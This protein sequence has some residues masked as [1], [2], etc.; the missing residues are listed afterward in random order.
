MMGLL[1][2]IELSQTRTEQSPTDPL[3]NRSMEIDL[4]ILTAILL[5]AVLLVIGL[6]NRKIEN[7]LIFA[8][9]L[10]TILIILILALFR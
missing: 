2:Q 7:M 9:F 4:Y 3:I 6:I 8:L 10:S 1:I 5:I